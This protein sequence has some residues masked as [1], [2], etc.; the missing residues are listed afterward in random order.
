M[1][2]PSVSLRV[3]LP[4]RAGALTVAHAGLA[5]GMLRVRGRHRVFRF[6]RTAKRTALLCVTRVH[7]QQALSSAAA[8]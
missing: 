7:P 5:F 1:S 3:A 6:F 8:A 2:P 4:R